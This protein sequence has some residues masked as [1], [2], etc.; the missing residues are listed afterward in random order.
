MLTQALF[1]FFESVGF[2][3]PGGE[4]C[5]MNILRRKAAGPAN[6]DFTGVFLPFE[7]RTR[8]DAEPP[9]D[10]S[11]NGDLSLGGEFRIGEWHTSHYHGNARPNPR[12]FKYQGMFSTEMR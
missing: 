5:P 2:G 1:E 7:N 11:G 4:Y 8:A 12:Y 6:H 10:I 3:L 9:P